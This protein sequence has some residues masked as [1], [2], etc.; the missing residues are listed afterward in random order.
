MEI[1]KWDLSEKNRNRIII[2]RENQY[3][4]GTNFLQINL[5]INVIRTKIPTKLFDRTWQA[6]S[7]IRYGRQDRTRQDTLEGCPNEDICSTQILKLNI[8]L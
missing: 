1:I 4:N 7:K 5:K 8:K 3:H 6:D 2:G